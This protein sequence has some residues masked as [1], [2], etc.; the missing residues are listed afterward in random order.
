[1]LVAERAEA[2][3]KALFWHAQADVHH[4]GLENHSRDLIRILPESSFNGFEI[5]EGRDRDVGNTRFRHASSTGNRLRVLDIAEVIGWRMRLYADQCGVVQAVI[6]TFELDDL[7]APRSGAGETNGV[8][9][10]F[11]AAVSEA[12]HLEG[13][14]RA[15]F[16]GQFPL[17]VMGHAISGAFVQTPFDSL[18]HRGMRMARH[19]RAKTKIVIKV[20]VAIEIAE[21]AAGSFRN[22]DGIGLVSTIVAGHAKRQALQVLLMRFGGLRS[23]SLERVEL[24]LQCG[25]HRDVSRK[26]RPSPNRSAIRLDPDGVNRPGSNCCELEVEFQCKLY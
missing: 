11:G 17:H 21:L 3:E 25:V 1:M 8:H 10:C 15:D 14:A 12:A 13:K 23:T 4:D 6:S 20:F 16:L 24:F 22:K 19:E 26:L 5:V 2:F 7:V 9:G 18:D